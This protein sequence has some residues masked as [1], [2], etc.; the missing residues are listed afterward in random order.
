MTPQSG[1]IRQE[2]YDLQRMREE[3]RLKIHLAE[4][5]A[6]KHWDKVE[7]AWLPI[8]SRLKTA[9]GKADEALEAVASALREVRAAYHDLRKKL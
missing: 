1:K 3:L 5:D 4:M 2:L 7:A 8:E 6:R 9:G